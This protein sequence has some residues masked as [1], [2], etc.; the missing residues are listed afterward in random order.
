MYLLVFFRDG[1]LEN[2]SWGGGGGGVRSTKK[3]FGQGK[4]K[5]KK[6]HARH[7]TLKYIHA[8]AYKKFVQ[9]IW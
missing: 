6:I 5:W 2:L 8:M 7:L 1:P 3:I 4:I 9:G